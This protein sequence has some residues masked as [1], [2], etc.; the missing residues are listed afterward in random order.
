MMAATPTKPRSEAEAGGSKDQHALILAFCSKIAGS[1][2]S[3][4]WNTA[5]DTRLDAVTGSSNGTIDDSM[6]S[7]VSNGTPDYF[8]E[9]EQDHWSVYLNAAG[10]KLE[11]SGK[12][13]FCVLTA[14]FG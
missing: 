2:R 14:F 5:P 6:N 7:G 4:S 11:T 10:Q 3:G 13:D 9:T 12:P 1:T 8:V